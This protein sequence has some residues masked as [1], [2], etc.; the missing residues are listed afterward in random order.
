MRLLI[1]IVIALAVPVVASGAAASEE[2]FA[3]IVSGATGGE[4]Y[5]GQQAKWRAALETALRE[6]LGVEAGRIA[7]LSDDPAAQLKSTRE[8][9][10][11]QLAS[12]AKLA[13]NDVLLVVLLGHGSADADEAKFNL[14]GPDLSAAEWREL[15]RPIR[16]RVIFVN[17]TSASF[18]F[19][20][21][22]AAPRRVVITATDSIAQRFVTVFPQYFIQALSDPAADIDKNNRVSIWEAFSAASL[23]V[24]QHYE[25]R[26]QLT[27]E[28][29][30]LDDNGDGIGREAGTPGGDGT[31]ASRIYLDASTE[32]ET[33][34]DPELVELLQRR[35]ALEADVDEL[36]ARKP[37]MPAADYAAEFER[38]MID[39]ARVSR[40]IRRR[41]S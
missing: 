24:R 33:A 26:G 36:R 3:L 31:L 11:R 14:V 34:T 19:L 29:A 21:R 30:L 38:L 27:T 41:K 15:L 22:L 8:E 25:Q 17:T 35:V 1:G 2:Q 20:E 10:R 18:P 23:N 39:L 40:E 5:V 4:P 6:K 37:L 12:F 13:Q 16:A 7:I 32:P 28:R 9:V